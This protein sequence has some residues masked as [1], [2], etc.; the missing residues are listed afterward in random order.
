MGKTTKR[1][2]AQQSQ[3]SDHSKNTVALASSDKGPKVSSPDASDSNN[4]SKGSPVSFKTPIRTSAKVPASVMAKLLVFTV[5]LFI[6]PI[7]TYFGSLKYLFPA[8]V[9]Y[10]Y[11]LDKPT[12]AAF[13]AAIVANIVV[14]AYVVVAL[15]EDSDQELAERNKAKRE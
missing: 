5:L 14:A 2:A 3:P 11:G 9:N 1:R 6:L 8:T 7:L 12:V 15:K 10:F 4:A 13:L